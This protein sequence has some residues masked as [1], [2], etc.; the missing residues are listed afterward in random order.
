MLRLIVEKGLSSGDTVCLVTSSSQHPRAE[1]AVKSIIDFVEKTNPK[2]EVEVL[3]LD[4]AEVEKNIA[5]LARHVTEGLRRG[6]V[7][8]DISGGPKGLVLALYMACVVAGAGD[9]S[10]TLETT[11]ERI[12]VPVL[13]NP[14][15]G[16][17]ERQ[18]QMLRSLPST[19][20]TLSTRMGVSK[21]A[22][23]KLLRRLKERG[24]VVER[25][26]RY[27]VSPA[28]KLLLDV[29]GVG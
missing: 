14:F 10:L 29:L 1:N 13:P 26:G 16:I 27:E 25:S 28:G 12:K 3:R 15:A 11:G 2:V 6:S 8:V 24:L 5:L 19:V 4:E 22:A 18:L 7:F 9:V 20:T 23:S 17:T 21:A